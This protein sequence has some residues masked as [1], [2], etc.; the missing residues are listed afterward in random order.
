MSL[1][2]FTYRV[3]I[4]IALIVAMIFCITKSY[5]YT[6]LIFGGLILFAFAEWYQFVKKEQSFYEKTIK[7]ILHNDFTTRFSKTPTKNQ[8]SLIRLYNRLKEQQLEQ[9]SQEMIFRNLLDTL[10][11]GVL[12]LNKKDDK[13]KIF[14][15]NDYFSELFSVPKVN[16]WN[17]IKNFIPAVF[18]QIE[19]TNYSDTKTSVNI[20]FEKENFETFVMQ[21]SRTTTYNQNYFV[22]LLDPI[23]KIIDRK[24]KES[25]VNLMNVISHELMNSLTPIQSLSKSLQGITSQENLDKEDKEDLKNGLETISNRSNHLQFFVENYRKLSSLPTPQKQMTDLSVLVVECLN[26]MQPLLK[27]ENIFVRTEI[28]K[29]YLA[30]DRQQLEQVLINLIAN[31]IYALKNTSDKQISIRL[32]QKEKRIT[33]QITDNGMGI[34]KEIETKLF[35]PFF[36]TRKE[37]AGIGLALSKNII[38]AHGGYLFFSSENGKTTFT[39]Q[40]LKD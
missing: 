38:E 4:I 14:L 6:A 17:H 8:E 3:L 9:S 31:S 15:M 16:S 26:V 21:T 1:L 5:P 12:I 10:D 29:V 39:V 25:W 40:F 33:I 22:L 24:E 20:R 7:A 34:E 32:T 35:L 23:Q 37:G 19:K 13:W 27:S 30:V 2:S 18:E 11:S 36:T 28:E